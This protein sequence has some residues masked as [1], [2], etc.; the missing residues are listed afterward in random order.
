MAT[1]SWTKAQPRAYPRIKYVCM[2]MEEAA[3]KVI[4]NK[5]S[6]GV[7]GMTVD[8]LLPLLEKYGSSINQK[9]ENG[10]YIP[11]PVRRKD[12]PKPNGKKRMLGIPTV[13]D[14]TI[15]QALVIVLQD[16]FEP[17]LDRKSVV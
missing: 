7:D 6:A 5:G 11:C 12:I 2:S 8:E 13:L 10:A 16:D 4:A 3:R 15:Q 14:R 9:L 1:L 17:Q